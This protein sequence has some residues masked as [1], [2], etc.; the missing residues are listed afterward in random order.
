MAEPHTPIEKKASRFFF[1]GAK[2]K[3]KV[4]QQKGNKLKRSTDNSF[5]AI[6]GSSIGSPE[7]VKHNVH[8]DLDFHWTGEDPSAA[9]S[10]LQKLGE[11]AF[12]AVYKAKHQ[13]TGLILAIKKV[14]TTG[15]KM[16]DDLQHEIDLLKKCR[17]VHIVSYWGCCLSD[18]ELW[19]L[20]D[21]CA[22]G[23]VLNLILPA[24]DREDEES[25]HLSIKNIKEEQ[26]ASI[27]ASVVGGLV[28]LHA[29]GIIHRDIKSAN[30]LINDKGEPKIADF[31]VS[32]Q[33]GAATEQA[34]IIGTPLWMAPEV[35]RGEKNDGYAADIWSLGIT[36]IEI[37][38][39]SPPYAEENIMRALYRIGTE[40]P[41][42]LKEAHKY[43]KEM[44]DF[45]AACLKT[46]PS[47][48]PSAIDLMSLPFV[49]KA[50]PAQETL[51]DLLADYA[52]LKQDEEAAN[53]LWILVLCT[54]DLTLKTT[55]SPSLTVGDIIK[56]VRNRFPGVGSDTKMGFFL[57]DAN[58][59]LEDS[60]KLVAYRR[61]R[62]S[63][64]HEIRVE[65]RLRGDDFRVA[66]SDDEDVQEEVT[67][68]EGARIVIGT[69]K[70][71]LARE[72]KRN[73]QL[74]EEKAN[75]LQK[76]QDLEAAKQ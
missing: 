39:G 23:S 45:I 29:Q 28:Y 54:P 69:L 60:K 44:N 5:I 6:P 35:L 58:I 41:S 66:S 63:D 49:A 37:V 3:E 25:L 24:K 31:G 21:Y 59:W 73:K 38:Q 75:L 8:V 22:L 50:R 68:L 52:K 57:K 64:R 20:M 42:K 4:E 48:R 12:G 16:K 70:R 56:K 13:E 74:E 67:S 19:I 17:Q 61:H 46:E 27:M 34:S 51:K 36:T 76:I 53:A 7:N 72:Q 15:K 9:F 40:P 32:S 30:I 14:K 47:E 65:V 11:G 43:S 18:T 10:I 55:V 1:H 33:L 71:S 2:D 26:V 62:I